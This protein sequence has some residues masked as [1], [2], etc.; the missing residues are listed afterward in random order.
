MATKCPSHLVLTYK[1][2]VVL[3]QTDEIYINIKTGSGDLKQTYQKC[4]KMEHVPL[5][6]SD[7]T[8][9]LVLKEMG[10][11]PGILSW[12][13]TM[14]LARGD[15]CP[16]ERDYTALTTCHTTLPSETEGQTMTCQWWAGPHPD[17]HCLDTRILSLLFKAEWQSRTF[18]P[19]G[20][21]GGF[22]ESLFFL[23]RTWM[24]GLFLLYTKTKQLQH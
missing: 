4:P 6:L 8:K 21:L 13:N 1:Q 15:I 7:Y 16:P 17:W 12:E 9:L 11:F 19:K 10:I 24:N 5:S 22:A 2:F 23:F 20:G 18:S 3:F 14:V